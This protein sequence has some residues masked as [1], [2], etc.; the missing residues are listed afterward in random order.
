METNM[1]KEENQKEET[2][3]VSEK[4]V[5]EKVKKGL[6]KDPLEDNPQKSKSRK[7]SVSKK[8]A[9][10][11]KDPL[12]DMDPVMDRV[13]Q[14]GEKEKGFDFPE[15][16]ESVTL[17]GVDVPDQKESE[18]VATV[19]TVDHVK[20]IDNS[21]V[22]SLSSQ[23]PP[24]QEEAQKKGLQPQIA[25]S[26]EP[27]ITVD[28]VDFPDQEVLPTESDDPKWQDYGLS[29]AILSDI[30]VSAEVR[31]GDASVDLKTLANLKKN[32]IIELDQLIQDTVSVLVNGKVIAKGK[33]VA[34]DNHY[35]V[36]I[37]HVLSHAE[38]A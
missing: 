27:S 18:S 29:S 20:T 23:S 32:T 12:K 38:M 33:V 9:S 25:P 16:I 24:L 7:A 3:N 17:G 13:Y 8:K 34:V 15:T 10:V 6:A 22:I 5:S 4:K 19:E 35:A 28:H 11:F 26:S 37:T 21:E 1:K 30:P 2:H 14:G 31:L 36:Q